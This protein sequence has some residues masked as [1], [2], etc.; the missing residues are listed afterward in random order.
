MGNRLLVGLGLWAVLFGGVP[1]WV[2]AQ[3]EKPKVMV[4]IEEKVAGVFGTTGWEV[5]GQADFPGDRLH[6]AF[7]W[8]NGAMLDLGNLGVT[9]S[10][11]QGGASIDQRDARI[12]VGHLEGWGRGLYNEY[13][14]FQ[15]SRGS[16]GH[17]GH[18]G[19]RS[20]GRRREPC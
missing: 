13:I 15:R 1:G 10:D 19:M 14:F 17:G 8:K 11:Y 5:V 20:L 2:Q 6:N 12:E 7:L 3:A 16:V 9:F 4:V 18:A